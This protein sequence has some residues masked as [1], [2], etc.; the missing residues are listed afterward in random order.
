MSWRTR[1]NIY[2]YKI[3]V[4]VFRCFL[5]LYIFTV[6]S[7]ITPNPK[8]CRTSKQTSERSW[9]EQKKRD[10]TKTKIIS[11]WPAQKIY[12]TVYYKL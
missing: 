4:C 10:K 7:N 8:K 5:L 12:K 9:R 6:G 3:C 1:S 2:I 11:I